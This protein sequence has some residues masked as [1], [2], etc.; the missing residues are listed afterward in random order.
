MIVGPFAFVIVAVVIGIND[1]CSCF[2]II[3]RIHRLHRIVTVLA[4]SDIAYLDNNKL[5]DTT[6]TSIAG[7]SESQ[8]QVWD[9]PNGLK[10]EVICSSSTK[11]ATHSTSLPSPI[12]FI[13]GS[14][15]GAWCY[16]EHYLSYFNT[17]GHDCYSIS[18]RGTSGTTQPPSNYSDRIKVEQHVEDVSLVLNRIYNL[19][20]PSTIVETNSRK[21]IAPIIVAHSFGGLILM[22]LLEIR[23]IREQVAA[24]ALLCSVPPSGNT[25]MTKRFIRRDWIAALKIVWGFV[26]KGTH[27]IT[28]SLSSASAS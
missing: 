1:Q 15:H 7:N 12:L 2:M 16:S 20:N 9:L 28:T 21:G 13:H 26:F 25:D 18:L 11:D 10:M 6:V 3:D 4:A 17:L 23:A 24:V 27:A 19:Y 8:K 22:K 14:F 5:S